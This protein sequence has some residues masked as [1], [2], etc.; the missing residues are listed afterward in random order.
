[1][2][3]TVREPEHAL[4]VPGDEH[5]L[6]SAHAAS[7]SRVATAATAAALAVALLTV[8][9]DVLFHHWLYPL[10]YL[11]DLPV[12]YGYGRAF[13]RGLAPYTGFHPEYPPLAVWLMIPPAL[14]SGLDA[15]KYA[16]YE[17]H[18]GIEMLVFASVAATAVAFTAARL[19]RRA[20]RTFLS[21]LAFVVF[22]AAIG[23]LVANR[24]D[25]AV[26]A[27]VALVLL[28][29][30][31]DHF[32]LAGL[33]VGAG[34]AL[35][36]TPIVLLP[37]V[38]FVAGRGRRAVL[39]VL[40]CA[41]VAV[42][43]FI[44]YL[45]TAP[46]GILHSFHYQLHRPLEVESVLALPIIERHLLAHAAIGLY[47]SHHAWA[48]SGA[49]TGLAAHIALFLLAAALV[50]VTGLVWRRR[51]EIRQDR[52]KLPLA[53]VAFLLAILCFSGVLSPQYVIWM[54]P[55]AALVICDDLALGLVLLAAALL[56]QVEFPLAFV[57]ILRLHDGNLALLCLRNVVLV[58]AFALSLWRLWR[59]PP[60]AGAQ[61]RRR[62]W[63]PR[64]PAALARLTTAGLATLLVVA[65]VASVGVA[66]QVVSDA[67]SVKLLGR[68]PGMHAVKSEA[69][70]GDH[71]ARAEV[72]RRLLNTSASEA[73]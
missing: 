16:A 71:G 25:I 13:V 33:L 3:F 24:F 39:A 70:A 64:V 28:A 55:A 65:M 38:V 2:T 67:G 68:P 22:V 6:D 48:L 15:V 54:L 73:A 53:A 47:P 19:W 52:R 49:R 37:L 21:V 23:P 66:A 40:L 31:T 7:R 11:T 1:M 57:G 69:R 63:S 8:L 44:P 45:L 42:G 46:Q 14:S 60:A 36:L 58:L 12:D 10:H 4:A 43:P 51:R 5:G 20:S 34:F 72:D 56:T 41:A 17:R 26:A 59:L 61:H 30:A 18:F 35:K 27:V 29:L 50:G 9:F 62:R 32:P